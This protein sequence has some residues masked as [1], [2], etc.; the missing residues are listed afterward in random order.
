[1]LPF[2]VINRGVMQQN[3]PGRQ[4]FEWNMQYL[5]HAPRRRRK[6]N[7]AVSIRLHPPPTPY[8]LHPPPVGAVAEPTS[9]LRCLPVMLARSPAARRWLRMRFDEYPPGVQPEHLQGRRTPRPHSVPCSPVSS[10]QFRHSVYSYSVL[11]LH[12]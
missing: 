2:P 12:L 10:P 5:I 3:R 6:P 11:F 4:R 9:L 1:M 7:P 8:H